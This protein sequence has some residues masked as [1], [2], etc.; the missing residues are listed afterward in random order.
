M[1]TIKL[2]V[3]DLE[4]SEYT[5]GKSSL[6]PGCGHDQ[7]SNVII[8]AAWENGI[9]P[10][11]IA[12]MSGT[13]VEFNLRNWIG[14]NRDSTFQVPV[15][16]AA[17]SLADMSFHD[18]LPNVDEL[19]SA[20]SDVLISALKTDFTTIVGSQDLDRMIEFANA[21][22]KMPTKKDG[23]IDVDPP[24]QNLFF[25]MLEKAG[26]WRH[27]QDL[28][29]GRAMEKPKPTGAAAIVGIIHSFGMAGD[30]PRS[31]FNTEHLQKAMSDTATLLNKVA[32]EGPLSGDQSPEVQEAIAQGQSI[33]GAS[34]TPNRS[35][36]P[37]YDEWLKA[38]PVSKRSTLNP[39]DFPDEEE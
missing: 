18:I 3:I 7:I 9:P 21:V 22:S 38:N 35:Q 25:S 17:F 8:Q 27:Y 30:D 33:T 39:D 19:R 26:G 29:R 20:E 31:V 37:N 6:C 32:N 36:D 14:D 28:I 13:M 11:G 5:G 10:E 15:T 1:S 2:N 16:N 4:K 23:E 12:K 34:P 24:S